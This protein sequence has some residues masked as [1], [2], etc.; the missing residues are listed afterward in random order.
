MF[1]GA[2]SWNGKSGYTF[3]ARAGDRGEPGRGRDTF[4][5]VIK[6]SRGA[7]VLNVSGTLDDGNIEAISSSKRW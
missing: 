1:S 3:E 6:D 4:A 7:V 5:L 2:G